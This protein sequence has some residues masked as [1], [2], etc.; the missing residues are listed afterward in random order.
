MAHA[1]VQGDLEI[2]SLPDIVHSVV[3]E[4]LNCMLNCFTLG[5]KNAWFQC[6]VNFRFHKFGFRVRRARCP[7]ALPNRL[8]NAKPETRNSKLPTGER[9]IIW[10]NIALTVA[11]I[12]VFAPFLSGVQNFYTEEIQCKTPT[13]PRPRRRKPMLRVEKPA[14]GWMRILRRCFVISQ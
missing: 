5:I 9:K 13:H 11:D 14:L 1:A 6:D 7:F 3:S 2:F 10:Q 4:Q 8:A 12:I